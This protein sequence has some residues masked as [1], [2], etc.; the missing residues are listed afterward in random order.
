MDHDKIRMHLSAFKDGE[1]NENLRDHIL[2]HLKSCD[3]C[4][5]ELNEF[6]KIDSMVRELPEISIPNTFASGILFRA[7][8][9]KSGRDWESSVVRRIADRFSLLLD[10][11]LGVFP[12][13]KSEITGSLDEFGDFPPYSLGHAYFSLISQ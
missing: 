3:A 7:Q 11:V 12:G 4:R 9:V 5:E 1:L 13:Y 2:R 6:E 10:S 8:A